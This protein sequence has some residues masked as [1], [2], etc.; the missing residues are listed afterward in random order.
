MGDELTDAFL[1]YIDDD[2][3]VIKGYCQIKEITATTISFYT[4]NNL[5]IIPM[6]RLL[7]VKIKDMEGKEWMEKHRS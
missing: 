6:H 5:V 1:A 3:K 7:K 2:D 4:S